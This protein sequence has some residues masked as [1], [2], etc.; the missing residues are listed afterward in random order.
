[1]VLEDIDKA[2]GTWCSVQKN[3]HLLANHGIHDLTRRGIRRGN[4]CVK[5]LASHICLSW[6]HEGFLGI[7]DLEPSISILNCAV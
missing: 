4:L 7:T 1:M 6:S 5:G 2:L 3:G